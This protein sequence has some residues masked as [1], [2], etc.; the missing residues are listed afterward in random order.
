MMLQAVA[1]P[2]SSVHLGSMPSHVFGYG[3]LVNRATLRTERAGRARLNGWRRVWRHSAKRPWAFLSAVPSKPSDWIDGLLVEISEDYW[4]VLDVREASFDALEVTGVQHDLL[5]V[6][7]IRLYW[8]PD[9]KHPF[10]DRPEPVLLS[11]ID[12][13][14]A[15]YFS[16]YGEPGVT[17][18]IAGIDGW[19]V[20][21]VHDDRFD[22]IYSRATA[23]APSLQKIV[24]RELARA[25]ARF[26]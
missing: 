17:D 12:T 26:V 22:P 10:P 21:P 13:C 5:N 23:S 2:I 4:S 18:F 9:D 15:G 3:S 6:S 16:E 11:Y 25:G 1:A 7:S 14:A 24:D 8:V 20:H 19:S